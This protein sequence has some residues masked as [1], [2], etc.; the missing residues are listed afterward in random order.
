MAALTAP[1]P[2]MKNDFDLFK[3]SGGLFAS[4]KE[5][6]ILFCEFV[7]MDVETTPGIGEGAVLDGQGAVLVQD[8]A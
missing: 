8:V 5:S 6:R 2:I 1:D 4:T 3:K 7:D